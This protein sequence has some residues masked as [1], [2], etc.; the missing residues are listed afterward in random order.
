MNISGA[1]IIRNGVKLGFPFI[2]AIRSVLP[3][4]DEFIVA[5]GDSQDETRKQIQALADPRIRIIDT[6]WNMS[7][8]TGGK[9]LSEETNKAIAECKGDWV[10]YI[11]SDE[12]VHEHE[13]TTIRGA[14]KRAQERPDIDGIAFNYFH[15]Y[16]SYSTVQA[17]RNWYRQEVRLVRN[18]CGIR[19]H[20]DAQ[21]FRR[22]NK[23]IRAINSGAHVYHYG[24]ARPPQVMIEKIKS[25][26]QLWH[27]DSWIEENCKSSQSEDYFR[28]LGNLVPFT[29]T[30]PSV[31]SRVAATGFEQFIINCRDHYLKKRSL[32]QALRD[33][34]RLTPLGEHRN[35][36]L[37]RG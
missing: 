32:K 35:F 37:V 6:V 5:V 29:G 21:G 25:F 4:C 27:D 16:G 36:T 1:T 10:F 31:M 34:L 23:K 3:L 14:L 30:H 33:F 2:E 20:G 24:W 15:F 19:S 13:Y 11:Q 12:A 9:V 26:H 17:G 18:H 8:R 28:D 22:G 7:R